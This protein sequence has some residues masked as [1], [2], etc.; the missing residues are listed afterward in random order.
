MTK[1][2]SFKLS[3]VLNFVS[4]GYETAMCVPKSYSIF[5]LI[6]EIADSSFPMAAYVMHHL[7]GKK[8]RVNSTTLSAIGKLKPAI[9]LMRKN[10]L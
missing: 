2:L 8:T 10:V 9:S 6:N 4:M 7:D 5:F 1:I 3:R